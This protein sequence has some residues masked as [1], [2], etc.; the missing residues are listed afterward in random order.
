[1]DEINFS[2]VA[3]K[4]FINYNLCFKC[5]TLLRLA[6][7]IA[8]GIWTVEN[9]FTPEE[10]QERIDFAES[11]GF[12]DAPINVGFGAEKI[13][14]NV[15]NNDRAMVDDEDKAFLLWQKAKE[16]LPKTIQNRAAIGLN[17]RLRFYRY[18]KTQK[19][20]WH[21]DGSFVRPNG[22]QSLL[23]FMVYLNEDFLGGETVFV[24][25]RRTEIVPKTG[26]MLAFNHRIF[27]EG[28]V[29]REGKKYVLRSDV[30][31]SS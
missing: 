17:E 22:E 2:I 1:M 18:E 6:M 10:C 25:S 29:V 11:I 23:T 20:S 24:G 30:M 7:E 13:V 28:S 26:L 16:H 14:N 3:L 19:F 27:H 8:D 5:E 31:F 15:R 21:F 4:H 12:G 9:F